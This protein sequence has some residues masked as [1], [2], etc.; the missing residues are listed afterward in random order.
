MRRSLEIIFRH[1]FQLLVLIVLFPIIGV[2]VAYVLTPKT[3]PSSASLWAL[4]RYAVISP[5]G[6]ETDL[7]ATPAQTQ[8]TA[9][10]ELLQT[11]AFA[12]SVVQ[13][14]NLA[15]TLGLSA[16]VINDHQELDT[17]LTNEIAKN[18]IVN[19]V[20]YNLFTITYTNHNPQI[21]EQIVQSVISNY[22]SQSSTLSSQ[23]GRNLLTGYQ[24][25]LLQAQQAQS[26]AVAAQDQYA[27]SHSNMTAAQL[28]ADPQYQQLQSATT[29]AQ[30][31]VQN[32]QNSINQIQEEMG[33]NGSGAGTLYQV[34]DAPQVAI[35]PTS[36]TKNYLTDGGIALGVAL[37]ADIIYLVMLIRRDRSIYSAYDLQEVVN[38]PVLMQLPALG[39]ESIVLL[40]NSG[41]KN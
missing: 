28:A 16:S 18:V 5:T 30:Q 11:R 39:S 6:S 9:L 41:K 24:Q 22:G 15:P 19:A 40:S 4:H 36:R 33:A 2:A 32:I 37:L 27:A 1:P 3:Y 26:Q 25:Q 20:G 14:I 38:L 29:T 21:A 10:T 31:N 7:S 35:Q 17:A 12:L 34:V 8:A 23:E 13:G